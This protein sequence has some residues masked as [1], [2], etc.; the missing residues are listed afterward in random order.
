[1]PLIVQTGS[2]FSFADRATMHLQRVP[3]TKR[4]V[5]TPEAPTKQASFETNCNRSKLFIPAATAF[6][7]WLLQFKP[8]R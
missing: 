4:K 5:L 7:Y 3:K 1:M 8:L 6:F 2:I